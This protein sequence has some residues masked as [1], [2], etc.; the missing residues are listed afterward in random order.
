[1][2]DIDTAPCVQKLACSSPEGNL[3]IIFYTYTAH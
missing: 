2:A 3:F 1:M